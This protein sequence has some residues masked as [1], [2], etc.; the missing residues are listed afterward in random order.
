MLGRVFF[1][2]EIC[3]G[4]RSGLVCIFRVG[5]ILLGMRRKRVNGRRCFWRAS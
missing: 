2:V 5:K 3:E 1:I 4:R